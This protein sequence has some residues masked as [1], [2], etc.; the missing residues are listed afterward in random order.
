[1]R[2]ISK[3]AAKILDTLTAGLKPGESRKFGEKGG[4][5]M[6]VNVECLAPSRFSIS[7]YYM[8]Y[9]DLVPDPD[10]E[11]YRAETGAWLP[12]NATMATGYYTV[13]IEFGGG[14]IKSYSPR[15]L[16]DLCSFTTTWMRNIKS[17][18]PG[19]IFTQEGA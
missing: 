5:F 3:S 9:G 19:F 7:H 4:P 2:T 18:Q 15:V 13:A 6:Q 14:K 8:Q 10:M 16:R 12:V 11:F 1:M 17:Q